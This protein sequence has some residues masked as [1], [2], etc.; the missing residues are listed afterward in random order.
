ME[1]MSKKWSVVSRQTAN[2][3]LSF[4]FGLCP[5]SLWL[6]SSMIFFTT[7]TAL[8]TTSVTLRVVHKRRLRLH[9]VNNTLALV[10]LLKVSVDV[11]QA[12]ILE[13]TIR[14]CYRPSCRTDSSLIKLKAFRHHFILPG[15]NKGSFSTT[16]HELLVDPHCGIRKHCKF[17][18]TGD[19]NL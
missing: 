2:T 4:L 7:K 5:F 19:H 14:S 9:L 15:L 17:L 6:Y 10:A 11:I 1:I 13:R 3:F 16:F 8:V 12:L 18:R